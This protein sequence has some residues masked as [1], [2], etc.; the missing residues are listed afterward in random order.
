MRVVF[1]TTKPDTCGETGHPEMPFS[2]R[3]CLIFG[4]FQ[5]ISVNFAIP[6]NIT[7]GPQPDIRRL[8]AYFGEFRHSG[9]HHRRSSMKSQKWRP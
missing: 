9:Q 8:S 7:A 6:D 4:V 5:P 1:G 3:K 2:M